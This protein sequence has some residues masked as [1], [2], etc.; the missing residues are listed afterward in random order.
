[1][2]ST[3]DPDDDSQQGPEHTDARPRADSSSV[4]RCSECRNRADR[5][6][7]ARFY[8][9]DLEPASLREKESKKAPQRQARRQRGT[10]PGQ[11]RRPHSAE[12]LSSA[13]S[14]G[15]RRRI[16]ILQKDR[17]A[18][19]KSVGLQPACNA[20]EKVTSTREGK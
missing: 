17:S 1:M 11:Q 15:K 5:S 7:V 6:A 10:K 9:A 14:K 8:V 19:F 16:R 2:R 18:Q 20:R 3:E 4:A 13:T 12:R